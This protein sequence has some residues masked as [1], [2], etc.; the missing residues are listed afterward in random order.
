MTADESG[1]TVGFA[2]KVRLCILVIAVSTVLILPQFP[3]A[4]ADFVYADADT[5][6]RSGIGHAPLRP[7]LWS[8]Q[9]PQCSPLGFGPDNAARRALHALAKWDSLIN[10]EIAQFGYASHEKT[11]AFFPLFPLLTRHLAVVLRHGSDLQRSITDAVLGL[12]G[13]TVRYKEPVRGLTWHVLCPRDYLTLAALFLSF[14]SHILAV[15]ALYLL[16]KRVLAAAATSTAEVV[17]DPPSSAP[18]PPAA[19]RLAALIASIRGSTEAL[20]RRRAERFAVVTATVFALSPASVF[21]TA[22]YTESLFCFLSFAFLLVADSAKTRLHT[23]AHGQQQRRAGA[24]GWAIEAGWLVWDAF[25]AA[26]LALLAATCRSNGASLLTY[27]LWPAL[28]WGVGCVVRAKGSPVPAGGA[29]G[30]AEAPRSRVCMAVASACYVAMHGLWTVALVLPAVVIQSA[31]RDALCSAKRDA[32]TPAQHGFCNHTAWWTIPR[33]DVPVP[34][35]GGLSSYRPH[36]PSF[37]IYLPPPPVYATL[38]AK[39]WSVGP[40][41]YYELKQIP[42]FILAAP[43]FWI[44]C[45]AGVVLVKGYWVKITATQGPYASTGVAK[46]EAA[47]VENDGNVANN[48]SGSQPRRRAVTAAKPNGTPQRAGTGRGRAAAAAAASGPGATLTPSSAPAPHS[49]TPVRPRIPHALL[50]PYLAHA[51]ALGVIALVFMHVQVVTRFLQACP[52][53]HG[54][55]AAAIVGDVALGD[56]DTDDVVGGLDLETNS[57]ANDACSLSLLSIARAA[58]YPPTA[59]ATQAAQRFRWLPSGTFV[60]RWCIGYAVLGSVAFSLFLPFT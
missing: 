47:D 25:W 34:M 43:M 8:L 36:W 40:F 14:M 17:A 26:L 28:A 38:Q 16:T 41:T 53:V 33:V 10:L 57:Q 11:W 45:V 24:C 23:L 50:A 21:F 60:L 51:A 37:S 59:R 44:A 13:V 9:S 3:S 55:M 12:V 27:V 31:A 52:A 7:E 49:L 35:L 6:S 30:A 58:L 4:D 32:G 19:S 15:H 39:Y 18:A 42:N 2:T 54:I 48:R 1:G 20:S 46:A 5:A 22:A 56:A 29:A